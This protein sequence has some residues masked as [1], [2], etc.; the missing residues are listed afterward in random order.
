MT[1][2]RVNLGDRPFVVDTIHP[3]A[4]EIQ[5]TRDIGIGSPGVYTGAL[6]GDIGPFLVRTDALGN[7]SPVVIGTEVFLG[8][9]NVT[10]T[11]TGSPFG[12]NYFRVQGPGG[13]DATS[14]LVAISGKVFT[15]A[16]LPTPIVVDRASYS[17]S[18]TGA[19]MDIFAI[20]PSTAILSFT[21]SSVPP[22]LF[23]MGGDPVGR[24]FGQATV[25]PSIL[26][27]VTLSAIATPYNNPI[28]PANAAGT[29]TSPIS[30]LVSITRAEYS[31]AAQTLVI[32][33]SSSDQVAPPA[34]SYGAAALAMTITPPIQSLTVTGLVM[35]PPAVTVTSSAGGSDT[36]EVIVLP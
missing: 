21:D 24:F 35:P 15:G 3:V 30:D 20:S 34:L 31:K 23:P 14:N 8:D 18:A 4:R 17:R 5:F 25:P 9:P 26:G 2:L 7:V 29:K 10:T 1:L 33:A 13:I 11:F 22:L 28:F 6:G 12:T 32:E 36:E 19:Q 16:A 27:P